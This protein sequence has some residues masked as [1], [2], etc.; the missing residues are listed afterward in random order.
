[1][2]CIWTFQRVGTRW[3]LVL[4]ENKPLTGEG[5]LVSVLWQPGYE[6]TR[7]HDILAACWYLESGFV[8]DLP[9]RTVRL[10]DQLQREAPALRR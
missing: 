2:R 1:M 8:G 10:L 9:D 5:P 4:A 7:L 6:S 3:A